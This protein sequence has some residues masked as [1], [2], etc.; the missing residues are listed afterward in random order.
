MI[1]LSLISLHGVLRR[2]FFI[3]VMTRDGKGGGYGGVGPIIDLHVKINT[4]VII[5]TM[6]SSISHTMSGIYFLWGRG[7][8]I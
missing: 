5:W 4:M 2:T 1:I 6:S 3:K 8:G 7:D